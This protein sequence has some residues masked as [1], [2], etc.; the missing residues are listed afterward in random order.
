MQDFIATNS[1]QL[2]L[3]LKLLFV[4]GLD[5]TVKTLRNSKG[6]VYYRISISTEDASYNRLKEQ[7]SVLIS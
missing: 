4:E 5:P 2:D 7:F 3:C 1:K 6:K